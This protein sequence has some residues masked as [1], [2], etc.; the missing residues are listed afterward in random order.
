MNW[1]TE[2]KSW[3]RSSAPRLDGNVRCP[4]FAEAL[5]GA[6]IPD[7]GTIELDGRYRIE[8]TLG[9]VDRYA[10]AHFGG[11]NLYRNEIET[12]MR[13][14]RTAIHND[15]LDRMRRQAYS[16]S[17]RRTAAPALRTAQH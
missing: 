14:L 12:T 9:G 11:A 2:A 15:E 8:K 1:T 7:E 4:R 13:F 17:G 6:T 3:V 10:E 5:S 16:L